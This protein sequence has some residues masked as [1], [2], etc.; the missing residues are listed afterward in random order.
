MK[1]VT[2][3]IGNSDDKLAQAQWSFF[4]K[5]MREIISG[6]CIEV[7]F[8]GA[9]LPFET[10]QNACFV[11]TIDERDIPELKNALSKRSKHYRQDSIAFTVGDTEFV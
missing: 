9:S 6:W 7:H 8:F 5:N 2:V 10:W 1:T 4:V 3:Q 11:F